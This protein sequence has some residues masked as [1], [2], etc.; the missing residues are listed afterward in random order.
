MST[1]ESDELKVLVKSMSKRLDEAIEKEERAAA[2]L[3]EAR[4]AIKQERI[5]IQHKDSTLTEQ[6][7]A[8]ER[9][10]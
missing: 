8:F 3:E 4:A 10:R 7:V 2:L 9:D 5:A 1:Q 6:K